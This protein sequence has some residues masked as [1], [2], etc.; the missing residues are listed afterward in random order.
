MDEYSNLFA[1]HTLSPPFVQIRSFSF[2]CLCCCCCYQ[3]WSLVFHRDMLTNTICD[4][5]PNYVVS[6]NVSLMIHC[7][8]TLCVCAYCCLFHRI[9]TYFISSSRKIHKYRRRTLHTQEPESR[10]CVW[11][12]NDLIFKIKMKILHFPFFFV[13]LLFL[14]EAKMYIFRW[15]SY[16]DFHPSDTFPLTDTMRLPHKF[17]FSNATIDTTDGSHPHTHFNGRF[18]CNKWQFRLM[19]LQPHIHHSM[20]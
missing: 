5:M 14:P 11:N 12:E 1:I 19:I 10:I 18:K 8:R 9:R 13:S 17:T 2:D 16:L 7:M 20:A 3:C 4:L 15:D 6:V